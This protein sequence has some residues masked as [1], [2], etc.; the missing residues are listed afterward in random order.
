MAGQTKRRPEDRLFVK[1]HRSELDPDAV[2]PITAAGVLAPC[3]LL[4]RS[5][6]P[7]VFMNHE[8]EFRLVVVV[9]ADVPALVFG[10]ANDRRRCRAGQPHC[11]AQAQKSCNGAFLENAFH[12]V[13]SYLWTPQPTE[14]L[15]QM[16][17]PIVSNL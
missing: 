13:L 8:A 12:V 5:P 1:Q 3:G 10:V 7:V 9:V 14:R 11:C 17:V 6:L 15:N 2:A 4:F 16:S